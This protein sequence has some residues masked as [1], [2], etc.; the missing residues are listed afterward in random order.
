MKKILLFVL[1]AAAGTANAQVFWT[2]DFGTGC[3]QANEAGTY[4]G[5]DGA[6]TVTATGTNDDYANQWFVSATEAGTGLGN[7]GSG[8]TNN[9]SLTNRTLHLGAVEITGF[10][11]SDEGATY[12]AG[13]ICSFGFCA[14]TSRRAESPAIDCS[15]KSDIT[16]AF[17]YFE[18]GDGTNDDATL[19]YYDGTSWTLLSNPAK[20]P[21]GS[22]APKGTWTAFSISL[23]S[24]ADNNPNVKIGF[25]WVNNDDG[26]GTD[27]SFAVDDI[28]LSAPAAVCSLEANA[29]APSC[30]AAC[31][32]AIGTVVTGAMP[33][34][35]LWSNGSD[36][37]F[38]SDLCAG[39][40]TVTLTDANNC[41]FMD[42]VVLTQ[43]TA[44]AVTG[45][46]VTNATCNTCSNGSAHLNVSGGSAP[47]LFSW[48]NNQ[49]ADSIGGL[50]PG[51]YSYTVMDAN[52]CSIDGSVQ[53][54]FTVGMASVSG[55]VGVSVYPNPFSETTSLT[56]TGASIG[57]ALQLTVFNALGQELRRYDV[58]EGQTVLSKETMTPGIYQYALT[59]ATQTVLHR[60]R[61]V[62]Q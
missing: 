37:E 51:T 47:Y 13:G 56:V 28:E 53:V 20:T 61:L 10:N 8:C 29:T 19:W 62:V 30:A 7:C 18:N 58:K 57:A 49:F 33:Y 50:A 54:Q 38:L 36:S 24:S 32:G 4:S 35:I 5:P 25:N 21:L 17:N 60:G 52:G 12:N 45:I 22:C 40:Y 14:A 44:L 2:E 16:L 1:L 55:N 59:D 46:V 39:T 42:T 34:S 6:W 27:P 23:P 11:T 26:T 9:A 31:D 43:P 48:S 15:G 41:V 3:T